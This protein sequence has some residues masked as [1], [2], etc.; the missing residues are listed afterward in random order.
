[1]DEFNKE[2]RITITLQQDEYERLQS[3]FEDFKWRM[4]CPFIPLNEWYRVLMAKGL[5][6]YDITRRVVVGPY[7]ATGVQET[8]QR[9]IMSLTLFFK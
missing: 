5:D 4:E 3:A 9:Q 1:M 8:D 7:E 2:Q 6:E